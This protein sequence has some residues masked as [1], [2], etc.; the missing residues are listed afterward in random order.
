MVSTHLKNISQLGS[1]SQVGMKIKNIWNHHLALSWFKAILGKIP[2]LNHHFPPKY[3]FREKFHNSPPFSGPKSPVEVISQK[4]PSGDCLVQLLP[5][6]EET[7]EFTRSR[8]TDGRVER[9]NHPPQKLNIHRPWK[10]W[11]E[12][13]RRSFPIGLKGN[14]SGASC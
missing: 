10:R 3:K 11:L 9:W 8:L 7:W 4:L 12:V 1:F 2:L 6:S 14:F 5:A 13:E